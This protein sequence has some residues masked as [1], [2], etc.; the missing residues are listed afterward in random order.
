MR[1]DV[2]AERFTCDGCGAEALVEV[3]DE[4]PYGYHGSHMHIS[5]YGGNGGTWYAC[6]RACIVKAV[7]RAEAA[8]WENDD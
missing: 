3:G 2:K 7:E 4:L 6:K 1:K 8:E 5:A